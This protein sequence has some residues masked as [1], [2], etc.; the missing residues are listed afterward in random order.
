MTI[1]VEKT[2]I[3]N[4]VARSV[5]ENLDLVQEPILDYGTGMMRNATYLHSSGFQISILDTP[6][7]IERLPEDKK[8]I[9]YRV[10]DTEMSVEE[11]FNTVFCTF[12]LNVVPM[13]VTREHILNEI[14][15]LL[16][17]D[18][19]AIIEVRR[20]RGIENCKHKETFG[21]GYLVGNGTVRTFQK[22]YE[23]DE[24]REW[25]SK[26]FEVKHLKQHSDS[27]EAV[28]RRKQS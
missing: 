15:R 8:N 14:H 6:F 26:Y 24:F 13:L 25:I 16:S 22:G 10:Y 28:V 27:I 17:D 12:V 21:D 3:H 7:Q 19:H 9:A 23:L 2:A 18:G 1:C 11:R 20:T 5:K 4:G